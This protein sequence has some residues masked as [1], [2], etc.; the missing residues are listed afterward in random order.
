MC[1]EGERERKG[2]RREG[3]GEGRGGEGELTYTHNY[4][5]HVSVFCVWYIA[6]AFPLT[7]TKVFNHK[8]SQSRF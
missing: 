2:G 1:V 8:P 3:G 6:G 5:Y 4:A 7:G